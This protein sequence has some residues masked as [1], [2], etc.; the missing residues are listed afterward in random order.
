MTLPTPK[1]PLDG[2]CS[3]IFNNTLYTYQPNAF[4]SLPLREGAQWTQLPMGVAASGAKCVQASANGQDLLFIVGGSTNPSAKDYQGLQSYNFADETWRNAT[5]QVPVAQNRTMHGAAFLNSSESILL[6]AGF[7]DDDFTPSSQTFLI[8][9]IPPYGVLSFESNAPPTINPMLLPF[10]QTDAAMIGVGPNN[11]QIF[12]F[13]PDGGWQL[14]GVALPNGIQNSSTT[15]TTVISESDGSKIL[16][17]FDLGTS[18]N[19]VSTLVLQQP[20]AQQGSGQKPR[21][22]TTTTMTANRRHAKRQKRQ[23]SNVDLPVYNSTLAPHTTRD[24]FS[25]AQDPSGLVVLSGGTSQ[26]PLCVFNQTGNQWVDADGF[27]GDATD[28]NNQ[29]TS[30]SALAS[31]TSA[32]SSQSSSP[33]LTGTASAATS[34]NGIYNSNHTKDRSLTI[35]GAT[36]GAIFGFAALLVIALLILRYLRQRRNNRKRNIGF[37]E[38]SK[39]QMGFASQDAD[40]MSD[41]GGS[42]A[43]G[44]PRSAT[45]ALAPAAVATQPGYSKNSS[46]QSKRAFFHK[47][48]DSG[49]SSKSFF[50]KRSAAT[51]PQP[52]A[53]AGAGT[54]L[55]LVA[56]PAA[57]A[58][59]SPEPRTEP[60]TDT[61]WSKYFNTSTTD[62]HNGPAPH[63]STYTS[64]TQSD[65]TNSRVASSHPH[66]S[67]EVPPLNVRASQIPSSHAR[68]ESPIS[69]PGRAISR[70]V[71]SEPLSPS[72]FVSDAEDGDDYPHHSGMESEGQSSWT[73]VA[74]SSGRGSTWDER[75]ASSIY[76]DSAMFPHPGERVPIPNFPSVPSTRNSQVSTAQGPSRGLR[77]GASS[78]FAGGIARDQDMPQLESQGSRFEPTPNTGTSTGLGSRPFPRRIGLEENANYQNGGTG[79]MSWLNL[80]R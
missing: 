6:Y 59:G 51:S 67:A 70:D 64:G 79:D 34:T 44:E 28:Q 25:L 69:L 41:T 74:T 14:F 9:V 4:Q 65:Y 29:P 8:S 55:G 73:P 33:S 62:L 22:S 61:G 5:P 11:T 39:R 24:G 71:G 50:N 49:G 75:P 48:G 10:N 7:Q 58:F 78:D 19:Q 52:G 40:Q 15:Q 35:L 47:P 60:R 72:T 12:T 23:A 80:G 63:D 3:V 54:G 21:R 76:A 46:Q 17:I 42:F 45:A 32:P 53:G 20:S 36:L 30:T 37:P 27:F 16:E 13:N 43:S 66:E 38:D 57:V 18:P 56:A 2:H 1:V 31:A 77:T 68:P 26:D